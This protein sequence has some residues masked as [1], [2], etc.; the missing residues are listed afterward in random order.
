LHHEEISV[1]SLPNVITT[2][3]ILMPLGKEHLEENEIVITTEEHSSL[4]KRVGSERLRMPK[5]IDEDIEIEGKEQI[6]ELEKPKSNDFPIILIVEDNADLRQYIHNSMQLSYQIIEA[7]NGKDG[8]EKAVEKIPDLII[9]DVMMPIMDGFELC[10]RIKTDERTSHVPLILLTARAAKE[11][12]IEGLETGADDF[13]PKPFDADELQIRVKNLRKL[14]QRFSKEIYN[15]RGAVL[16]SKEINFTSI[17]EKFIQRTIEVIEQHMDNPDLTGQILG[18][19]VGMSRSQLHRKVKA[20]TNHAPHNFIRLL[21]LKR[22]ATM[23]KQNTG[24]ITEIA[25]GVGFKSVSH[26]TK[27]FKEQYGQTPS[28][29]VN[30]YSGDN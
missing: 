17:D 19:E 28:L 26:F 27:A 4:L 23:L 7:E 18:H 11:D 22:A 3:T 30:S 20:L 29:F 14:R 13:I 21:R 2:F 1:D 16:E 24:N 15:N 6:T 8:F 9:S 12:K 25:F 5:T 10:K